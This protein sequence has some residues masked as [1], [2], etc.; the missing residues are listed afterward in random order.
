MAASDSS[1]IHTGL[2]FERILTL[3]AELKRGV[4]RNSH[5]WADELEVSRRT[6]LRDIEF[7]QT[8]MNLPVEYDR[9]ARAYRYTEDPGELPA[10]PTTE[11]ELFAIAV[12][13]K[14]VAQYEGT[15]FAAPLRIAFGKL[16]SQLNT[17]DAMTIDGWDGMLSIQ[18]FAT[19][20]L[21]AEDF[22]IL[23]RAIRQRRVVTFEYR[24]AKDADFRTRKVH[25]HHLFYKLGAWY[26]L[27]FDPRGGK[28]MKSFALHRLRDVCVFTGK[29]FKPQ[30]FNLRQ[31]LE[32]AFGVKG[33][34][35]PMKVVL[36]FRKSIARM[37]RER[38][39]H[40]SQQFA[41]LD[42]GGVRLTMRVTD[43]DFV[44]AWVLGW[45]T[46]ARVIQPARLRK[47]IAKTAQGI[48]KLYGD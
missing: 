34:G 43:L 18:P 12:A 47:D 28:I 5:E 31:Y 42:D 1:P 29:T 24:G 14:A 17:G 20:S 4:K 15:P 32:N 30:N 7:M 21:D 39:W 33:S 25:P 2:Q 16:L 22:E 19:D 36:E 6:I 48:A 26:V 44:A 27:A 23:T 45:G 3:H 35:K 40:S 13:H 41:D 46:E 8:R 38:K 9:R 37:I 11:A 10:L